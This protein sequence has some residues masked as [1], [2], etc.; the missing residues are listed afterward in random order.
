MAAVTG[1]L[2][3]LT[4]LK[5]ALWCTLGTWCCGELEVQDGSQTNE[6]RLAKDSF[7]QPFVCLMFVRPPLVARTNRCRS[8]KSRLSA[9]NKE[10]PLRGADLVFIW[11]QLL[12]TE[13][14]W[15]FVLV[16]V[17]SKRGKPDGWAEKWDDRWTWCVVC[18]SLIPYKIS[19]EG[20]S[21]PHAWCKT[22]SRF[23]VAK[24]KKP[25]SFRIHKR[26]NCKY[27]LLFAPTLFLVLYRL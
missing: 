2:W 10:L 26:I 16:M 24:I 19:D 20:P 23:M 12:G 6:G 27:K 4:D 9:R 21:S 3:N 5:D 18:S 17:A 13:K 8:R 11:F 1:G 7:S 15:L 25:A 22:W 14:S